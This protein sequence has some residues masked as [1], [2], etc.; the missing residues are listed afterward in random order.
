MSKIIYG[1]HAVNA[2]LE[3]DPMC[4][5]EV[6]ILNGRDNRRLQPMIAALEASGTVIHTK[7]RQWLDDKVEGAVHQG[8]LVRIKED[9]QY[10]EKN[11]PDLLVSIPQPFLLILDGV[12]D[13]HNI[14]A[15]LRNAD[16]AGVHAI[17]VPRDRS[18]QLNAT[19]KKVACGAAENVPLI[20][21]T[22]LARTLRFLQENQVWIV[23]TAN[24]ANHT[25]YQ[26]KLTGPLALVM[27]SEGKGIRHLIRKHCDEL[28]SIPMAG[29]V[30]SLNVSVAAG[31]CLFEAVRQRLTTSTQRVRAPF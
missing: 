28:I 25:L 22:N 24:E 10:Q 31:I 19:A 18:A 6:F 5:L 8:I 14:G 23:G 27:G 12:T 30:L 13:P 16:A 29:S 9:R 2:L 17:I 11:L 20:R 26:S 15:C 21:V 3:R 7:N 1:I 4:F